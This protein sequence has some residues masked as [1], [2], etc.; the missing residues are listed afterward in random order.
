MPAAAPEPPTTWNVFPFATF[1]GCPLNGPHQHR[2]PVFPVR[3]KL[4]TAVGDPDATNENVTPG[5]PT[6]LP[7]DDVVD[8]VVSTQPPAV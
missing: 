6:A 5:T 1:T 3:S 7:A 8:D 2:V 4:R